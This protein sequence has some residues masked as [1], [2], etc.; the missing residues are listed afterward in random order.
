MA[1]FLPREYYDRFLS[2]VSKTRIPSPSKSGSF[3]L[4]W[5]VYLV[6]RER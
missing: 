6:V 3:D 5:L 4:T 1:N 2:D